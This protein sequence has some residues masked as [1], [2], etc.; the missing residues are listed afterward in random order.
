M[1]PIYLDNASTTWPKPPEVADSMAAFIRDG[2]ASPGR[3]AYA[4]AA[5]NSGYIASLRAKLAA[6]LSAPSEDRVVFAPGATDA[7]NMAILGLLGRAPEPGTKPKVVTT[8]LEH[9]A[10]H[11]PLAALRDRGWIDLTVVP[12]DEDGF[13]DAGQVIDAIDDNTAMVA[14]IGASNMLGTITPVSSIFRAAR[15]TAP[16]AATLVDA[17][18][19]T[20][21][22]PY[23]V[24]A[25]CIDLLVFPGHKSMMGPTGTG[26]LYVSPRMTGEPSSS[27][28]EAW[29]EVEPVRFGGTGGDSGSESMPRVMPRR[30]EPGSINTVGFVG[31]LAAVDSVPAQK[32]SEILRH[33]RVHTQRLMD[34]LRAQSGVRVLGPECAERKTGVVSFT[35]EGWNPAELAVLLDSRYDICVR[36]GLHC[37]PGAHRS[38]GTLGEAGA[39]R[40]SPGAY[41]TDGEI[42]AFCAAISE[43]C[44]DE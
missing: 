1:P 33:E 22:I 3:G 37:A 10:V 36:A 2:A 16:R 38:M 26:V 7:L 4:M 20:P 24:Q 27:E 32:R 21:L 13:I 44:A 12:S 29:G 41:T 23:D 17:S 35:I 19:T 8:T 14:L 6:M 34:H 31:L 30:L 15:E 40:A 11:R 43:I 28:P 18:Q 5:R 25:D 42:D 9:N 39:V